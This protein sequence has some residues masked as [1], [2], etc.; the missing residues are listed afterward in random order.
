[1]SAAFLADRMALAGLVLGGVC[2]PDA[3]DAFDGSRIGGSVTRWRL[4]RQMRCRECGAAR[5]GATRLQDCA[6]WH[7]RLTGS[8]CR[9]VSA[10]DSGELARTLHGLEPTASRGRW[11]KHRER[12]FDRR[13]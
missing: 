13:A 12:Q 8:Q 11:Q 4:L 3:R 1:V 9:R 10:L 7:L 6:G 2:R 5:A